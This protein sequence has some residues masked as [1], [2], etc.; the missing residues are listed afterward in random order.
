MGRLRILATV[1]ALALILATDAARADINRLEILAVKQ[2]GQVLD[3]GHF[4]AVFFAPLGMFWI[5]R[6]EDTQDTHRFSLV[7]LALQVERLADSLRVRAIGLGNGYPHG[8]ALPARLGESLAQRLL[9]DY[10]TVSDGRHPL[11]LFHERLLGQPLARDLTLH[12]GRMDSVTVPAGSRLRVF[13]NVGER[14][15][16]ADMLGDVRRPM[17]WKSYGNWIRFFP[18]DGGWTD[19]PWMEVDRHLARSTPDGG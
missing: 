19:L 5:L 10:G 7:L 1:L 11:A 17:V 14:H 2:S 13:G 6:L 9:A 8:L 4:R 16:H 3:H 15:G 12:R 18:A